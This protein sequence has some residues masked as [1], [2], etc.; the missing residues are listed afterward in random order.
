MGTYKNTRKIVKTKANE[1][2]EEFSSYDIAPL[3]TDVLVANWLGF[4][5]PLS[6]DFLLVEATRT[7]VKKEAL[8]A[9]SK[10]MGIDLENLSSLLHI[11]SRTFQRLPANATLDIFS[12][13]QAIEMALVFAKATQVFS[14]E[15][16]CR[17]WLHAPLQ[18]LNGLSPVSVLDTGFGVHMVLQVLGR[19]E[20]GVFS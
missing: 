14:D 3:S 10:K 19:L 6:N 20:Q 7:G 4:P 2:Q 5:K 8:L 12:S 9:L 1:V 17:Q 16:S 18:A 11:S 15:T 13:E